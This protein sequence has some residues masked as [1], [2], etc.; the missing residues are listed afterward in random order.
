MGMGIGLLAK[1]R[2]MI[3]GGYVVS[4]AVRVDGQGIGNNKCHDN[5][6]VSELHFQIT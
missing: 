2:E 6:E 4:E 1:C 3:D 5:A